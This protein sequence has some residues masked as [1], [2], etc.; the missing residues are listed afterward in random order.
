MEGMANRIQGRS[1][2][3]RNQRA[4]GTSTT[5]KGPTLVIYSPHLLQTTQP[6]KQLNKLESKHLNHEPT[7]EGHSTFKL[8]YYHKG[9]SL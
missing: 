7:N 5:L 6:S 4:L 8:Q 3:T 2:G 9:K 1:M